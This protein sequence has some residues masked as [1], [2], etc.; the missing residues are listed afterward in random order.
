VAVTAF[1]LEQPELAAAI[2]V[3]L[4]IAGIALVVLI[5]T[6]IRRAWGALRERWG[7]A[8]P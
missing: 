1:S 7:R 4:L 2:A 8:P 3:V 5:W 6:R